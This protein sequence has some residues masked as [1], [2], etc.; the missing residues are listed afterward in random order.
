MS[1]RDSRTREYEKVSYVF[2]DHIECKKSKNDGNLKLCWHTMPINEGCTIV[3]IEK[4]DNGNM[5][6]W[7][8]TGNTFKYAAG[9]TKPGRAIVDVEIKANYSMEYIKNGLLENDLNIIRA[10]LNT[11]NLPSD[12]SLE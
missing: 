10:K 7:N 6:K 3:S 4:T 2:T 8:R 1:F 5:K 9:K 11:L 12:L